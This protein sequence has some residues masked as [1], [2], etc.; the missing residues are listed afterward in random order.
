M[1]VP[2][3]AGAAP[4]PRHQRG[5]I[6]N[7]RWVLAHLRP[8]LP[9]TTPKPVVRLAGVRWVAWIVHAGLHRMP[10]ASRAP[11]SMLVLTMAPPAPHPVL[12]FVGWDDYERTG[13]A[14]QLWD[15]VV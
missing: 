8:A 11:P 3:S 2:L 5:H 9:P 14:T 10:A 13:V 7:P 6:Q 12:M 4:H 1:V 15:G